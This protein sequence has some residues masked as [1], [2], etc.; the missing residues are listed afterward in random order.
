MKYFNLTENEEIVYFGDYNSIS[1][2]DID[3]DD[4]EQI[5]IIDF[6]DLKLWK[7]D[8]EKIQKAE[9]NKEYFLFKIDFQSLRFVLVYPDATEDTYDELF[10]SI[11]DA[12]WI[13]RGEKT[14]NKLYSEVSKFISKEN[15]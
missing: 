8:L 13:Y 14:L 5:V 12:F 11:E 3:N 15:R 9:K 7:E 1:E 6:E 10:D 4:S 2:A